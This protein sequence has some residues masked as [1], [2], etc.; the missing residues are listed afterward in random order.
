MTMAGDFS[1]VVAAVGQQRKRRGGE[2]GRV[3]S[4]GSLI[5]DVFDA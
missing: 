4:S 5:R 1:F 2:T 3:R